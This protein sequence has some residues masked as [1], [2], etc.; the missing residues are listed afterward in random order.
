[1]IVNG[2]LSGLV[3][4]PWEADYFGL[5][6]TAGVQRDRHCQE[7]TPRCRPLPNRV[8]F[9]FLSLVSG[10]RSWLFPKPTESTQRHDGL[11]ALASTAI[12][13]P[14]ARRSWPWSIWN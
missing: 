10:K 11:G 14:G 7:K 9:Q 2:P 5:E 13:R 6:P 3:S 12:V 4:L 1:M 8:G